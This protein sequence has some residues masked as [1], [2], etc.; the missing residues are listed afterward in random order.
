MP[1]P[2]PARRCPGVLVAA[3]AG[4]LAACGP[5]DSPDAPALTD[6]RTGLGEDSAGA[7]SPETPAFALGDAWAPGGGR[8]QGSIWPGEPPDARVMDGPEVTGHGSEE[9]AGRP[10]TYADRVATP[11]VTVYAPERSGT[12]PVEPGPAV[13]VLP[14]GGYNVVAMDLE[15]TEACDWLTGIGVTCVLLKYRAPCEIVRPYRNCPTAHQDAQRAVRLTRSRAVEWGIDPDRIGVLGFSAGGHMVAT[16]STQYDDP[17][18]PPVDAVDETSA[19]P[20]FAMALYPGHLAVEGFGFVLNPAIRVTARTPPTFLVHAYDDPMDPVEN[21]LVYA[22][23]LWAAGVP[24]EVHV[25]AT[26]GHAFGLRRT[27]APVTA[28]PDRAEEWMR[29]MGVL[30]R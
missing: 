1:V 26:G 24:T 12:D 18:Y 13:V 30:G 3:L 2:S 28:W 23:S 22:D 9:V 29:A 27:D 8:E 20:D 6:D 11:T 10:W 17:L 16:I 4:A 7:P 19:R 5:G 21:T 25:Y 15:G 14:G